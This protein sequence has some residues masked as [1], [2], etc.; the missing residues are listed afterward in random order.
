MTAWLLP[1]AW[2]WP[3]LLV[4]PASGVR[5]RQDWRAHGAQYGRAPAGA[6][7]RWALPL[8]PLPALLAVLLVP[9]GTELPMPWF[10]LG[11]SFTMDATVRMY[12]GFTAL[13]WLAAGIYAAFGERGG[14][15]AAPADRAGRFD[16]L[17]LLAMAG[18]LWLIV[19]QDLFSFYAGFAMMGI[20]SYG[21]VVHDGSPEALRAGKVYLVMALLG[22]VVLFAGLVLLVKETGTTQP[23]PA[24]VT[25]LG[26]LT[27]GLLLLGL[28]VKAGM[29]PLHLWLPLAHPA[30]PVP[31]SAVLSGTM[32]KVA[33][34]GW[35]RFLPVGALALPGWGHWLTLMGLATMTLALPV[36][37]VQRDAKVILAYSS[38]AKMGFLMLMLGLALVQ[39][40][41]APVAVGGIVVYAAQHGLAKGGL[42]LGVGLRKHAGAAGSMTQAIIVGV[43]VFLALALAGAPLTSGAAAKYG[44]K[45]V[46]DGAEW[47]WLATAIAITTVGTTL[48]M[49]RFVWVMVRLPSHAEPGWRWTLSAW[50]LLAALVA[51]FP[52]AFGKPESWLSN[53]LPVG[54]GVGIAAVGALLAA[55]RPRMLTPL[56]GL[57]PAGDLLALL[58]PLLRAVRQV[59]QEFLEDLARGWEWL[60]TLALRSYDRVCGVPASDVE[61]G[62]RSWPVA[63]ALW[64][65]IGVVLLVALFAGRPLVGLSTA[66]DREAATT[67]A[68]GEEAV[69][70]GTQAA[71]EAS[72]PAP[73]ARLEQ[74]PDPEAI[75]SPAP[76]PT[77]APEA[78][79]G[80]KPAE[81]STAGPGA[82]D[83]E[84]AVASTPAPEPPPEPDIDLQPAPAP[85]AAVAPGVESKTA[86]APEP[87]LQA[88]VE[89]GSEPE[90]EP[91]VAPEA[92]SA[93]DPEAATIIE[94]EATEALPPEQPAEPAAEPATEPPVGRQNDRA[95]E[96][97]PAAAEPAT[98]PRDEAQAT[99]P[100]ENPCDP[101]RPY[102][103]AVPGSEPLTLARCTADG[104]PLAA[105]ALSR[106]LV[107]QVQRALADAGIDPGP[108]D[109]LM[110]PATRAGIA[111]FKRHNDV[112][113]DA[114]IDFALLDTLQQ[115]SGEP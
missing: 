23:Q 43:M 1:I 73:A 112:P 84:A 13:L 18:N 42:F 39:P 93:P 62:L 50:G 36:G 19:A 21:L 77:A 11:T 4:L 66:A 92:V 100:A 38:I 83:P 104:A 8:G 102:R 57:V 35:L 45:P 106:P 94:P 97:A 7:W 6:P 52:F 89:P 60:E 101:P 55:L 27:I 31:A 16:A 47:T 17:F 14:P 22:E 75:E 58:M 63:G 5:F 72:A 114:E 81:D 3:L 26:N 80:A 96:P 34:L 110:G 44:L 20:A 2:I 32:I 115:A 90:A 24:E 109:G 30:A 48:L 65:G 85:E 33:L 82:D 98:P 9:P 107:R 69:D 56:I 78:E 105:P 10:F 86:K 68:P 70:A 25:G 88:E 95:S 108:I 28:G 59:G 79:P 15:P 71:A 113:G 91:A 67:E 76:R 61:R 103:F 41:L 111:D 29:V 99:A 12:L 46:L 37:L 53:A 64:A 49:A 51:L 87:T 54:I 40:A 74:T